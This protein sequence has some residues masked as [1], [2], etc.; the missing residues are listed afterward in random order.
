MIYNEKELSEEVYFIK[1]GRVHMKAQNK[2][3]FRTYV[4]GS[5]FGE[6]E[7]FDQRLRDCLCEVASIE[8]VLLV[9]K[10]KNFLRILEE[11]PKTKEEMLVTAKIKKSKHLESKYHVLDFA[12]LNEDDSLITENDS[13]EISIESNRDNKIVRQ[14]TGVIVSLEHESDSKRRFRKLWSTALEKDPKKSIFHRTKT[15]MKNKTR[16]SNKS[17]SYSRFKM[18]ENHDVSVFT[19]KRSMS[20]EVVYISSLPEELKINLKN[21]KEDSNDYVKRLE[22]N[23]LSFDSVDS[24]LREDGQDFK[25][26][27]KLEFILSGSKYLTEQIDEAVNY[28]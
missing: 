2:I 26:T 5:Y 21:L 20:G 23:E 6:I 16:K 1:K 10:K 14:D 18:K 22:L 9:I 8:A 12:M 19:K 7:V 25:L 15:M 27:S 24:P 4:E 3:I 28:I 13:S 17:R 11:F